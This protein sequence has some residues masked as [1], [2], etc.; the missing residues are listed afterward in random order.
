MVPETAIVWG[1]RL[2]LADPTR[3]NGAPTTWGALA[4]C[5]SK[6]AMHSANDPATSRRELE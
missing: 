4:L 2:V 1:T 5:E 3:P 6:P